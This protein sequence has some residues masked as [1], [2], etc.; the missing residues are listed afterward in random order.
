MRCFT[1]W[2]HDKYMEECEFMQMKEDMIEKE[3]ERRKQTAL[4]TLESFVSPTLSS[5]FG[6][7]LADADL[8]GSK[9]ADII[10]D[11]I[12]LSQGELNALRDD[13]TG[14]YEEL[15]AEQDFDDPYDEEYNYNYG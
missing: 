3:L 7:M 14:I 10:L 6:R 1:T 4:S 12:K 5:F 15:M 9:D 2:A 11:T 8:E 13:D